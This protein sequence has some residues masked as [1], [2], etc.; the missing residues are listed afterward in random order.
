MGPLSSNRE[1]NLRCGGARRFHTCRKERNGT[2]GAA[3]AI[4]GLY[5]QRRESANAVSL[6][7]IGNLLLYVSAEL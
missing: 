5:V 3:Q 7:R 6:C 4:S 2:Y 1:L